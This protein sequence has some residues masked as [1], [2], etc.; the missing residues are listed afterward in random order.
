M[1]EC[2]PDECRSD[3]TLRAFLDR[4]LPAEDFER[5]S[6]H[7][8]A[9]DGC[10]G[11]SEELEA[12]AGRVLGMVG[13][14]AEPVAAVAMPCPRTGRPQD[15]PRTGKWVAAAVAVAA[16]WAA[17]ALLTPPPVHAPA[18]T[19]V[20]APT[21]IA[22]PQADFQMPLQPAVRPVPLSVHGPGRTPS[23]SLRP[24]APPRATLAGF[25]A[26][27]DDPIDAGVVMRVVLAQGQMQADVLYSP[28]GRPRAFRLVNEA[29]GK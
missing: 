11:R 9:C 10:R 23:R 17:L 15:R 26:L 12:R 19:T 4:E 27:D 24:A 18:Q 6:A 29:T 14:L 8:R 25:V 13:A 16:G 3:G 1:K 7:L 5:V 22:A 28:D 2:W 20:Q 21:A